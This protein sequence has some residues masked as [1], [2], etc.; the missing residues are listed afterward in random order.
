MPESEEHKHLSTHRATLQPHIMEHVKVGVFK[1]RGALPQFEVS[2]T[3]E[4]VSDNLTYKS[5]Q[6]VDFKSMTYELVYNCQNF[7]PV[8]IDIQIEWVGGQQPVEKR[9]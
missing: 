9:E 1:V 2:C 7:G 5:V 4:A 6:L 8:P 3:P